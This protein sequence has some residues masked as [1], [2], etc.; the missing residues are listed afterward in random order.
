MSSILCISC[1][2]TQSTPKLSGNI[3]SGDVK[4]GAIGDNGSADVEE[5]RGRDVDGKE[6]EL[7]RISRKKS[8]I[9]ASSSTS[10]MD[11]DRSVVVV[12][13]DVVAVGEVESRL[14]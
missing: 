9:V 12:V 3:I 6:G 7:A 10:S 14:R 2:D 13:V 5:S 4:G 8:S 1:S 11:V